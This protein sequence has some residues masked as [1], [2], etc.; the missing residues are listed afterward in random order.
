MISSPSPPPH[1]R[2]RER[3]RFNGKLLRKKEG[4]V[5]LRK[6]LTVRERERKGEMMD[7]D[8]IKLLF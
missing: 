6:R 5:G 4:S 2:E 7:G 8:K 3:E 1:R